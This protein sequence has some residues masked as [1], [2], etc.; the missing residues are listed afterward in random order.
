MAIEKKFKFRIILALRKLTYIYPPRN[1]AKKRAKIGPELFECPMCGNH[2]YT[3][4]KD[5][6]KVQE[7]F[8]KAQ[9][10]KMQMDHTEPFVPLTGEVDDWNVIVDRM[11]PATEGWAY[12]CTSC[13]SQK[14]LW[15]NSQRV[16]HR[17][18][19]KGEKK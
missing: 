19:K 13:H 15:E 11:F 12:I 18:E 17:K 1:E 14:T 4:K 6:D 2:I 5:I 8:P 16:G 3:G 9:V 7:K 10:G